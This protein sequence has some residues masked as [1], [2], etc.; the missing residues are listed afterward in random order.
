[1][2]RGGGTVPWR[3]LNL[4]YDT[5]EAK[6][7]RAA[8]RSLDSDWPTRNPRQRAETSWARDS[9]PNGCTHGR[10]PAPESTISYDAFRK[11]IS[12]FRDIESLFRCCLFLRKGYTYYSRIFQTCDKWHVIASVVII[13]VTANHHSSVDS[14]GFLQ[15]RVFFKGVRVAG[16]IVSSYGESYYSLFL[17]T[18]FCVSPP[19]PRSYLYA[20]KARYLEGLVVLCGF[21]VCSIATRNAPQ[22]FFLE[23]SCVEREIIRR[24]STVRTAVTTKRKKTGPLHAGTLEY[25]EHRVWHVTHRELLPSNQNFANFMLVYFSFFRARR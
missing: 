13:Y 5:H 15:V 2:G 24:P 8:P 10:S 1:M 18:R 11:L 4:R 16:S 14:C 17:F 9:E 19:K 23:R 3:G 7:R 12:S 21:L 25:R 6:S 20:G 22:Y